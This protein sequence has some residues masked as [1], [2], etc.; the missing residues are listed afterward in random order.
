MKT[1][2]HLLSPEE[3]AFPQYVHIPMGGGASRLSILGGMSLRDYFA[4]AALQ[5]VLASG[6]MNIDSYEGAAKEAYRFAN[7]M[8]KAREE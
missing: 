7:A 4:M 6:S 1:P 5:G 3:R 8:L 2:D